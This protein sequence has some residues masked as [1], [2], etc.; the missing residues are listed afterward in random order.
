M[1]S[2][3]S[4]LEILR[5]LDQSNCRKCGLPTC[6][7]FAAAVFKGEKDLGECPNMD[8]TVL[9]QYGGSVRRR[10]PVE[11]DR[12]KYMEQLKGRI[13]GTDLRS[14]A[15]RLGEEFSNDRLSIRCL[16]KE[17][18]VDT[19]GNI[20]TDLHVNPWIAIPVLHY[21]LDGAG[22]P[23]SGKWV[24]FRELEGGKTW[25]RLFG[26]RCEKPLKKVADTYTD[27]FADMLHIFNG[28]KAQNHYNSDISI[29]L[30]PLPKVPVL[31]CYWR[32][33]SG[34]DSDLNLFFDSTA[35]RN[36]N[37][38]SLFTLGTGLVAMFEKLAEKRS[39]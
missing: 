17:F 26:Q 22:L 4:P 27:L 5:L 15:S 10:N 2:L 16:G 12:D 14:A 1:T 24:P 36:L 37:I 9:A 7:A 33:D 6:T 35:E 31:I 39:G 23:V 25:H 13:A 38:D 28:K 32:P 30:H 29:V 21:I 3:K 20:F 11:R 34:L 18:S 19:N 8:P